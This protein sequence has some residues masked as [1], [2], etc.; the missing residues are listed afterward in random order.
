LYTRKI[1]TILLKTNKEME[2]VF[3]TVEGLPD[4]QVSNLG[5]VV[6]N[7]NGKS[8]FLKPQT[9]ALGYQHVRLYPED[10]KFGSYGKGRGKKPKLFKVHKLVA[11]TFIPKGDTKEMLNVNHK[12]GDKTNNCVE[13]LEWITHAENIQHSWNIGLRDNSAWKAA[14]KR[15]KQVKV[16]EPDGTIKYFSSQLYCS[17]YYDRTA[18]FV[19]HCIR[20]VGVIKRGP[21]KGFLFERCSDFPEGYDFTEVP[22]LEDKLKEYRKVQEYYRDYA[23]RRRQRINN[24]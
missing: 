16:T 7:K 19:G 12:D 24:K 1:L 15:Y 8:V 6:S 10:R 2:E 21:F 22:N 13:N 14:K 5:R 20:K 17:L 18:V 11:E 9:D 3:R 23:R 4:Y